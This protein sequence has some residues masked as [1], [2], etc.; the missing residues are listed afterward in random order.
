MKVKPSHKFPILTVLIAGLCIVL[1][2]IGTDSFRIMQQYLTPERH[3]FLA[4]V[5]FFATNFFHLSTAHLGLNL[6]I[7]IIIAGRYERLN[8]PAKLA[9]LMILA[10]LLGGSLEWITSDL[11]FAGL[12]VTIYALLAA[13]IH[14]EV[15]ASGRF[16]ASGK[17]FT[18]LMSLVLVFVIIGIEAIMAYPTGQKTALGAHVGGA[19]A[20]LFSKFSRGTTTQNGMTF[21]PMVAEDIDPVLGIIFEFDEDD[22]EEAQVSFSETLQHKYV[23]DI[24]GRA[25]GMSGFTIDDHGP[26][27]A[28]LSW[29]YV[30]ENHQRQG[31]GFF[32][33]Q[34]IRDELMNANIRKVFIATSDYKDEDDGTDIYAPARNF[35]ERKLNARREM[36]VKD[37]YDRGESKYVYSL[38]VIEPTGSPVVQGEGFYPVFIDLHNADE[39]ETGFVIGWEET[40]TPQD[41]TGAL[42]GLLDQARQKNG[43]AVFV[44]MPSGLSVNGASYLTAAGFKQIG[45]VS[46]YYAFGVDDTYWAHYFED[47]R[48]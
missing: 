9:V 48:S 7:W 35:Y 42:M 32:M 5:Y 31:I 2:T 10:S 43:H 25:V 38:P 30:D 14:D 36:V 13:Y 6:V 46:D 16:S 18:C 33:M 3:W 26:G 8:G 40:Q 17:F 22:G 34:Q 45:R 27:I 1:F 20:G 15:T 44:S 29:T 4:P 23:V 47:N 41:Q 12:S 24:N 28:W 11:N 39:S 19:L 21:R 37:Y